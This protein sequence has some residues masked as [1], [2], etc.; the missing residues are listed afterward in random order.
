MMFYN[1]TVYPSIHYNPLICDI[2]EVFLTYCYKVARIL[3]I[4]PM[5][6]G[7]KEY[8]QSFQKYR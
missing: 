3:E 1:M 4:M 5:F 7:K 8:C 2:N 6:V